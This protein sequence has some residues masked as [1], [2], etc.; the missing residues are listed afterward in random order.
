[1]HM[2]DV[3]I[4]ELKRTPL[5]SIFLGFYRYFEKH[6]I[7]FWDFLNYFG[8][9]LSSCFFRDWMYC[10]TST[11]DALKMEQAH[12]PCSNTAISMPNCCIFFCR[13]DVFYRILTLFWPVNEDELYFEM[14]IRQTQVSWGSHNILWYI[15]LTNL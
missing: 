1:M 12:K 6:F 7:I 8:D 3:I 15:K 5:R 4:S 13:P 14:Q 11:T 2:K 9:H 10:L